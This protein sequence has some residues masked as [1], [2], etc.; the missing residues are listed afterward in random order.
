MINSGIYKI[1]N[2][3]TDKIYI[4]S[5]NNFKKRWMEHE[6][7]LNKNIHKNKKLQHSWNKHGA[8]NFEFVA[9]EGVTDLSKLTDREQYWFDKLKPQ[10]NIAL[11]AGSNLGTKRSVEVRAKMS[12]WQ[13]GRKMS[14]EDCKSMSIAQRKISKWPH[15]KGKSC[16]CNDCLSMM[17]K[18][19]TTKA[20]EYRACK[21]PKR[22]VLL[23]NNAVDLNLI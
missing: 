23:P 18:Y 1:K 9:L 19:K 8:E 17:R 6:K 2:L 16:K 22:Y 15:E 13:I 14:V 5:T 21:I 20:R 7:Q 10:Y 12:A 11:V 3:I 4:G